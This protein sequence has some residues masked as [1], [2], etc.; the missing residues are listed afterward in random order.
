MRTSAPK[1]DCVVDVLEQR[2]VLSLGQMMQHCRCSR[3]TVLKAL[4]HAGY[5]SSYNCN[6]AF[7]TLAHIPDFDENG[8]W[9]C[10]RKRFSVH[11]S[12]TETVVQQVHQCGAGY[13]PSQ[14]EALLGVPCRHLLSRLAKQGRV[15]REREGRHYVYVSLVPERQARQRQA[16][17]GPQQVVPEP[18]RAWLPPGFEARSV[19]R[20]LALAVLDPEAAP[21]QLAARLRAEGVAMTADRVRQVFSH[22]ELGEKKGS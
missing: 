2:R 7:Y 4:R 1:R 19:I 16:R 9:C 12:L 10:Q 6:A 14:L 22:Y 17:F 3:M 20:V 5:Y 11:R 18:E 8:L 15:G 13:A 21:R